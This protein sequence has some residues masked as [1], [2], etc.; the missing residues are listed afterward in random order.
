MNS[1]EEDIENMQQ[2]NEDEES[3]TDEEAEA[4]AEPDA[5]PL[6][7]ADTDDEYIDIAQQEDSGDDDI[8]ADYVPLE[9]QEP[10]VNTPPPAPALVA[11]PPIQQQG[12]VI[13]LETDSTS[14]SSTDDSEEL[15]AVAAVPSEESSASEDSFVPQGFTAETFDATILDD[16]DMLNISILSHPLSAQLE[17]LYNSP[18][19]EEERKQSLDLLKNSI[20]GTSKHTVFVN[21]NLCGA[22]LLKLKLT[23]L[24][25]FTFINCV[26]I[27]AQI[28]KSNIKK[29]PFIIVLLIKVIIAIPIYRRLTF[30]IVIFGQPILSILL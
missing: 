16:I 11:P 12:V 25:G 21:L 8:V 30:I 3:S 18:E 27:N 9:E 28:G 6:A 10:D 19:K 4:E 20:N 2:Q 5:E 15:A 14:E 13:P 7:D 26:F 1:D 22:N 17:A 23:Q 29:Q 24:S